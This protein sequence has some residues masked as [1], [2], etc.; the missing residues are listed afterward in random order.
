MFGLRLLAFLFSDLDILLLIESHFNSTRLLLNLQKWSRSN[1]ST[2]SVNILN[3]D[4]MASLSIGDDDVEET[5]AFDVE[6]SAE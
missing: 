1:S 4:D 3:P 5:E 6:D 2:V